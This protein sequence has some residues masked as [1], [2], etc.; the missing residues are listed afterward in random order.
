MK[1]GYA[2]LGEALREYATHADPANLK[3]VTYV[4]EEPSTSQLAMGVKTLVESGIKKV[5]VAFVS[6]RVDVKNQ[7]WVEIQKVGSHII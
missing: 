3:A 4:A 5:E 6:A 7:K 1:N 2:A